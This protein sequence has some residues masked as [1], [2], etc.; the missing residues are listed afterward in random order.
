MLRVRGAGISKAH[1]RERRWQKLWPLDGALSMEYDLMAGCVCCYEPMAVDLHLLI[2]L[3]DRVRNVTLDLDHNA[4]LLA[5]CGSRRK[6]RARSGDRAC[7]S[8]SPGGIAGP[9]V[10]AGSAAGNRCADSRAA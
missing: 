4:V 6:R 1:E 7:R 5:F 9:T 10:A 3:L 8:T 2:D